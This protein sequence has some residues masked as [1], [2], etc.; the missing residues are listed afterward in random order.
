MRRAKVPPVERATGLG[1]QV[2]GGATQPRRRWP[3]EII[4]DTAHVGSAQ[5]PEAFAGCATCRLGAATGGVRRLRHLSARCCGRAN[6]L[7]VTD[8][9]GIAAGPLA[10]SSQVARRNQRAARMRAV[11]LDPFELRGF[12]GAA[13]SV[14][15]AIGVRAC[16][17]RLGR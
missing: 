17:A 12:L 8:R 13:R 14:S 6:S 11:L 4:G 5:R 10:T 2:W 15:S 1:G 16:C 9:V 3:D 7:T